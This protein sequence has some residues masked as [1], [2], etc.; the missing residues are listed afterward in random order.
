MMVPGQ[1]RS[2]GVSSS[3]PQERER[4]REEER[5]WE[6]GWGHV[7]KNKGEQ[8]RTGFAPDW[9]RKQHNFFNWYI[10][11]ANY[12]APQFIFRRH[13]AFCLDLVLQ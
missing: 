7:R 4:V 12:I 13:H 3:R 5:P 2:Q 9:L 1:P 11:L 10:V 8:V 6:P